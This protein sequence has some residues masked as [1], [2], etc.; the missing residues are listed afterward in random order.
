MIETRRDRDRKL[1]VFSCTGTPTPEQV[2][3]TLRDFYAE[4][5]TLH[6][7]W[8]YTKADLSALT[9][10]KIRQIAAFLKNTSHSRRGGR[11]ALVFTLEQL[12]SLNDR[13]PSMAELT[14]E[15]ATIKIFSDMGKAENWVFAR[16]QAAGSS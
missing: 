1:T 15:D 14:V 11:S 2:Q 9:A 5:P 16:E 3:S 4:A 6:T 10:D 7:I 8:D 12:S 13:L